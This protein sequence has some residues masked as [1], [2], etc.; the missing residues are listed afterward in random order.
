MCCW[1][2]TILNVVQ[3]YYYQIKTWDVLVDFILILWP[4]Y[5]N[6]ISRHVS[7]AFW[8]MLQWATW[9][10]VMWSISIKHL[11]NIPN[12]KNTKEKSTLFLS[13]LLFSL[14]L[15]TTPTSK[16]GI[17]CIIF[18]SS[19]RISSGRSPTTSMTRQKSESLYIVSIV[20]FTFQ[21]LSFNYSL[22]FLSDLASWND[23][24]CC[25]TRCQRH[26]LLMSNRRSK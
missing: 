3:S 7:I 20:L 13:N 22:T 10:W 17:I 15:N 25:L 11:K 19:R 18:R 12:S 23:D 8:F 5:F 4:L 1:N 6:P 9:N 16:P 21:V 24:A 2:D 26:L 14:P